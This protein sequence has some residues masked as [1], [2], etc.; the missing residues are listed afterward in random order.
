MS[1]PFPAQLPPP[2]APSRLHSSPQAFHMEPEEHRQMLQQAQKLEVTLVRHH[3]RLGQG[4]RSPAPSGTQAH[5]CVL[6]EA[7]ILS[8]GNCE[9]S[10]GH[11]GQRCQ[12]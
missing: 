5:P 4:L 11:S 8:K 7:N 12:W 3:P 9:T 1:P 2:C 10:Q 6:L